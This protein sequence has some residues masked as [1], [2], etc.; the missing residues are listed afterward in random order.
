MDIQD[1]NIQ[2]YIKA[3]LSSLNFQSLKPVQ[4]QIIPLALKGESLIV[5]S[6]TGSGKTHSFLIP[7]MDQLNSELAEVQAVVTAPS[8]ELAEQIYQMATQINEFRPNPLRIENYVGGTDKKRQLDKLGSQNQPQLVIGT[9]GRIF[10][11]MS[12]HALWVQTSRVMVVD[13]ADMTLDMGFLNIVDEIASRMP[14]DLQMMVFSATIPQALEVF[15]NKYMD[16]PQRI[17][18]E[19]QDVISP[20]IRNYLLNTK[21]QDRKA[22]T[23]DLLTKGHPFLALVF[24]NTK[25]YADQ[26]VDYLRQRGLKVAKIHGNVDSRERKRIMRQIR[27]LEFQ[28]VVATDLA[29]RGIDIPGI[30]LVINTELPQDL[31]FFVHRVGRTGRNDLPGEAYTFYEPAEDQAIDQLEDK[32]IQFI[33]VRW[34]DGELVETHQRDRRQR[35]KI[36]AKEDLPEIN[37]L[38]NRQKHKKVKPGYKRKLKQ[39]IKKIRRA[40]AQSKFNKK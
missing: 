20:T 14:E 28:Y 39:N 18:I 11:L 25:E 24:T 27:N 34:K 37:R 1:L 5:E 12:E 19:N 31:E 8:R 16:H 35:R 3:A 6:Q 9:P 13:E 10:D 2:H 4:E 29:A 32:G 30:S 15:L 7:L 21:Q 33:P 23:Y 17:K 38:V 36:K 40:H 26:L 22:L